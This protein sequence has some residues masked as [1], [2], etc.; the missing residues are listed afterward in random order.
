MPKQYRGNPIRICFKPA[1]MQNFWQT[2]MLLAFGPF[3]LQWN[4]D[5]KQPHLL[6]Q[7]F[8]TPPKLVEPSV[9]SS[10]LILPKNS[11]TLLKMFHNLWIL[12]ENVL[13]EL[14]KDLHKGAPQLVLDRAPSIRSVL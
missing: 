2:P 12:T 13:R 5:F 6:C 7:L 9:K 3:G 10:N 14:G 1:K 11:R 4:G 8:R